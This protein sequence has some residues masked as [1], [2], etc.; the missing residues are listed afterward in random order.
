MDKYTRV[1]SESWFSRIGKS[2]KNIF[3]GFILFIGAIVLLWWNEGR[4]VKTAKGL[5]EGAENV[6]VL[7]EP[8]LDDKNDNRLIHFHGEMI[9]EDSLF[10]EEFNIAVNAMKLMRSVEMYQ[11]KETSKSTTK[12]KV[13]GGKETVTEYSYSKEWSD[14][15][16]NSD[17]FEVTSGHINP[18]DFPYDNLYE[19]APDIYLGDFAMTSSIMSQVDDYTPI[20]ISESNVPSYSKGTIVKESSED[21]SVKK[22][23]I[24]NGTKSSP[25][26][27]DV[28]IS[29]YEIPAGEYSIIAQQHNGSLQAYTTETETKIL[30]VDAGNVSAKDMFENAIK[31]NTV[32]T[33]ILRFVGFFVMFAGLA[34][35][36][37]I[38]E[39][40]GDIIPFIGTIVGM[41]VKLLAG[42]ASF[43]V[44]MI[45]IGLAWIYYRPLLGGI[46]I[47][48]GL[49]IGLFF[50]KKSLDKKRV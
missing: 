37:S 47:A 48:I 10:D 49:V 34:A 7:D 41:G 27:G 35:M 38:F 19:T 40:I 15:L 17:E 43:L 16:I 23:F 32:I 21:Q 12:K 30:M 11:W 8:V 26:I 3:G 14:Q 36:G 42:V 25:S 4:A 33:W 29:F 13:G 5:E 45:T 22:I 39:T 50:Y 18:A 20:G 9:T 2:I 44:S 28:K 1:T 31:A 6:V 24:G 46:L